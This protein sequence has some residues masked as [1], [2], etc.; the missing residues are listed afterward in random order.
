MPQKNPFWSKTG[1]PCVFMKVT[2][3]SVKFVSYVQI[4]DSLTLLQAISYGVIVSIIP[5]NKAF[6]RVGDLTTSLPISTYLSWLV[7]VSKA[8]H[9]GPVVPTMCVR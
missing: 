7:A 3:L 9:V 1:K 6:N 4:P 5:W 8:A 2:Q